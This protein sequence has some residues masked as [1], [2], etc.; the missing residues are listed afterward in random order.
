MS[1][2]FRSTLELFDNRLKDALHGS[3]DN[4]LDKLVVE[5]KKFWMGSVQTAD[6][7]ARALVLQ[8]F[9]NK[10]VHYLPTLMNPA[11]HVI[12]IRAMEKLLPAPV[13]DQSQLFAV[14]K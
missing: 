9:T 4:A 14:T 11:K 13:A 5:V 12:S 1:A 6:D 7:A 8:S 10:I 3:D 2:V